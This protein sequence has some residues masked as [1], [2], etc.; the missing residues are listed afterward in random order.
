MVATTAY[1]G[2]T[3]HL[4]NESSVTIIGARSVA[5]AKAIA[6]RI[7]SLPSGELLAWERAYEYYPALPEVES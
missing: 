4:D 1:R 7:P 3:L 5:E 6:S 2:I